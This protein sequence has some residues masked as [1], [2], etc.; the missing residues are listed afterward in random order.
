MAGRR[1]GKPA[2]E[3]GTDAK[4][5]NGKSKGWSKLTPAEKGA[6]FDASLKNPV[7]YAY[8]NFKEAKPGDG[9]K[10]FGFGRAKHKKTK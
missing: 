7:G 4:D 9:G 6:E 3:Q 1:K 2:K 8:R 10:G 5:E